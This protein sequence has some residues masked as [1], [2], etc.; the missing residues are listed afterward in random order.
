MAYPASVKT[1]QKWIEEVDQAAT[2]VKTAAQ[3]QRAASLANQLNA[4][5]IRRFY[6]LLIQTNNF[7]VSASA[8]SGLAAYVTAQ[9]QNQ[10]A[11]PVAEFTAMRNAVISTLDWLRANVP[12]GS[13]GGTD[14]KLAYLFPANN[15]TFSSVLTFT[16]AQTAG[17]R[18]VL[19]ALI[20]TI[21]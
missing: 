8:V 13:F 2:H 5:M 7:F 21:G 14:Y 17:Y 9:K 18:T 19:D 12:A 16:S 20:A 15:T 6:D 10:V 11:D 1:H 3:Q 4:E